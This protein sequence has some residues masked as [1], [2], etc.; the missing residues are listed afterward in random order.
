MKKL[1]ASQINSKELEK[2]VFIDSDLCLEEIPKNKL[3]T[4]KLDKPG[5]FDSIKINKKENLTNSIMHNNKNNFDDIKIKKIS[6]NYINNNCQNNKKLENNNNNLSENSFNSQNKSNNQN[7]ENQYSSNSLGRLFNNY[8]QHSFLPDGIQDTRLINNLILFMKKDLKLDQK[9][10][11]AITLSKTNNPLVMQ[12][13]LEINGAEIL[14]SW[15]Q[16][17]RE[18]LSDLPNN[19]SQSFVDNILL[20]LLSFCEKLKI[21]LQD[22]KYS[23]IGKVVNK[24]SKCNLENKEIQTKCVE[25]VNKWKKIV[26]ETKEKKEEKTSTIESE[27][28]K[29]NKASAHIHH[30]VLKKSTHEETN[31]NYS[32]QDIERN[33]QNINQNQHDFLNKKK[34]SDKS[35]SINNANADKNNKKYIFKNFKNKKFNSMKRWYINNKFI[36]ILKMNCL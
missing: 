5:E 14:S 36:N 21:S 9:S 10:E 30:S 28:V 18:K 17:L 34:Y 8:Y 25:L 33:K 1:T 26:E 6:T 4:N 31:K 16:E 24:I 22:L 15:L 7:E 32:S 27:K 23:K 19:V 11:V 35:A 2:D 13:F 20:N 12:K 3:Y 29:A